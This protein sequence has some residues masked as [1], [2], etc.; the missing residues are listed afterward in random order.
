MDILDQ[1]E[2]GIARRETGGHRDPFNAM[3]VRTKGGNALGYSQIMSYNVP[4]WTK[5]ALGTPMTPKEFLGNEEAQRAVT[6]FKLGQYLE[7]YGPEGAA[8]AWIG[9]PGSVGKPGRRDALGTSVGDYSRDVLRYAGLTD[10]SAQ[11]RANPVGTAVSD[12]LSN[13]KTKQKQAETANPIASAVSAVLGQHRNNV[14]QSKAAE[15]GLVEPPAA[16]PEEVTAQKA[17][18]TPAAFDPGSA[19]PETAA[20][21]DPAS[22]QPEA[23]AP[24][25]AQE[26]STGR[27]LAAGANRGMM[28]IPNLVGAPIRMARNAI[29]GEGP[30]SYSGALQEMSAEADK[31]SESNPGAYYSGLGA[32]VVGS[33]V[34]MAALP[35]MAAAGLGARTG[36]GALY[37]G[38]GGALGGLSDTGTVEG[39]LTGGGTGAV[40]GGAVGA[41]A[42][43]VLRGVGR[44]LGAMGGSNR[45]ALQELADAVRLPGETRAQTATRIR[46]RYAEFRQA[47][48]PN[49]RAD[50]PRFVE[51]L[52]APEGRAVAKR[53]GPWGEYA[54]GD[55]MRAAEHAAA[56]ARQRDIAGAVQG[57][58][59][60]ASAIAVARRANNNLTR[61]MAP[62][63]GRPVTLTQQQAQSLLEPEVNLVLR[64][65]A[66]AET[67]QAIIDANATGQPL[68]LRQLENVRTALSRGARSADPVEAHLYRGLAN[69]VRAIGENASDEYAQAMS[70]Y[71]REHNRAAGIKTGRTA[72]RGSQGEAE[73]A[74]EF[75]DASVADAYSRAGQ[76]GQRQG[77]RTEL[78]ESAKTV[79]GAASTARRLA[80]DVDIAE[81]AGSVMSTREA[82]SMREA[83]QV[84]QRAAIG[85]AAAT[86]TLKSAPSR[87][88]EA[89][90]HGVIGFASPVHAA[91][92]LA[93]PILAAIKGMP[94][95]TARRVAELATDPANTQSVIQYLERRGMSRV[96]ASRYVGNVLATVAGNKGGAL[97]ADSY[98]GKP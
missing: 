68:T 24:K 13:Y 91:H 79:S 60:A 78:A 9:G 28:G 22:A 74:A 50:D 15:H 25:T 81:R 88:A 54:P 62:I 45:M 16:P 12:I 38:A 66:Y 49:V 55:T 39:T 21:F 5:E 86:P 41:A 35:G 51:L 23:E 32:G 7:K 73:T 17:T 93:G 42:Q 72:M 30:T 36:V 19:Q 97:V 59:P 40:L 31:L 56:V 46:E 48:G 92:W 26:G 47:F 43:P 20:A 52:T 70:R 67:R 89:A 33:A 71:A 44:V 61:A 82:G 90:L 96:D 34:P 87:T 53:I 27:A 95:N 18:P 85:S 76:V 11:Q 75:V 69:D 2:E 57:S 6:R 4:A 63:E 83:G 8:Q 84:A 65:P 37:G 64:G 94:P 14:A 80:E 58:K 98:G 77:F 3:G 10:V 1:L 29:T